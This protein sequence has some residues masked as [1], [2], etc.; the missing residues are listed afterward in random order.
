MF[1]KGRW[2]RLLVCTQIHTYTNTDTQAH[3]DYTY[4]VTPP[5]HTHTNIT[6]P[7]THIPP[8]SLRLLVRSLSIAHDGVGAVAEKGEVKQDFHYLPQS[9]PQILPFSSWGV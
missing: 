2:Q 5:P 6:D 1:F 9:P 7:Q 8:K 3:T 4:R